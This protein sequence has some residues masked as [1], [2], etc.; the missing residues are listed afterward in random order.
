LRFVVAVTVRLFLAVAVERAGVVALAVARFGRDGSVPILLLL[1]GVF[2]FAEVVAFF[3]VEVFA[4]PDV[5]LA[6][7]VFDA[8]AVFFEDEALEPVDVFFDAE[9]FEVAEAFLPPV[10]FAALARFAED[11]PF[12]DDELT[13]RAG[14]FEAAVVFFAV[15]VFLFAELAEDLPLAL[16]F[17][18]V[19][20][21]VVAIMH[22]S[23]ISLWYRNILLQN[24]CRLK[25]SVFCKVGKTLRK[26]SSDNRTVF[27]QLM[28]LPFSFHYLLR[29][30]S[31]GPIKASRV[32]SD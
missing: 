3:A 2:F 22:S 24:V 21:L 4:V 25:D 10:L 13:L 11:P 26:K 6:V 8:A 23:L 31:N 14:L 27:S 20:F 29:Q 19:F 7:D 1:G 28:L 32:R 9:V 17:E 30:R 12:A 18:A 16:L 15:A 5:L